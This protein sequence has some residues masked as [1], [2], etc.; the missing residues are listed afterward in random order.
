[1]DAYEF[2]LQKCANVVPIRTVRWVQMALTSSDPESALNLLD[3]FTDRSRDGSR[4]T[5][6]LDASTAYGCMDYSQDWTDT[7]TD[8]WRVRLAEVAPTFAPY[9]DFIDIC[10]VWPSQAESPDP[11]TVQGTSPIL[12]AATTGD[13]ITPYQ[14]AT[15]LAERISSGVLLTR[16]GEGHGAYRHGDKCVDAAVDRYL[17]KGVMPADGACG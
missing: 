10:Q 3:R 4:S 11:I 1:M 16:V 13:T 17:T 2:L 12:I 15:D 5:N 14:W 9:E 6:Y 7:D 8:A